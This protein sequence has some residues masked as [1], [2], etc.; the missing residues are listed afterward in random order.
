MSTTNTLPQTNPQTPENALT[1]YTSEELDVMPIGA[2]LWDGQ[3][4]ILVKTGPTTWM[5]HEDFFD[6]DTLPGQVYDMD[7]DILS[8]TYLPLD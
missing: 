4:A 5:V 2:R 8:D 3:C 6:D 7:S 1:F